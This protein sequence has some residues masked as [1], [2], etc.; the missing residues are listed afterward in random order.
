MYSGYVAK[1]IFIVNI[2]EPAVTETV[3]EVEELDK[4]S[5]APDDNLISPTSNEPQL[6]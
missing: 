6:I 2:T 3:T 4:G 1:T 5:L